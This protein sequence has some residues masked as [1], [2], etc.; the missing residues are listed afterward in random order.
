MTAVCSPGSALLDDLR[1]PRGSSGSSTI[2]SGGAI[3]RTSTTSPTPL[4]TTCTSMP[5]VSGVSPDGTETSSTP[6]V[7]PRSAS[8][9]ATVPAVVVMASGAPVPS[10]NVTRARHP[11][12]HGEA[13]ERD[14]RV[15]RA[16][17]SGSAGP[18]RRR[19][20]SASSTEAAVVQIRRSRRA[21]DEGQRPRPREDHVVAVGQVGG[22]SGL[23]PVL[24]RRRRCRPRRARRR[25]RRRRC[26]RRGPGRRRSRSP[27]CPSPRPSPLPATRHRRARRRPP[28]RTS[29]APAPSRDRRRGGRRPGRPRSTR[30]GGS[31]TAGTTGIGRVRQSSRFSRSHQEIVAGGRRGRRPGDRRPDRPARWLDRRTPRTRQVPL[32][33][34][35]AAETSTTWHPDLVGTGQK[36]GHGGRSRTTGERPDHRDRSA[37]ERFPP[38]LGDDR[39]VTASDRSDANCDTP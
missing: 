27:S 9:A 4:R 10:T 5:S 14:R 11:Q 20:R 29:G 13:G 30:C 2:F 1:R 26:A 22:R 8:S 17:T 32:Y 25:R 36:R 16:S 39:T 21:L 23:D 12:L 15:R 19:P 35:R 18:R 7:T 24:R 33:G 28:A 6:S 38:R 3:R 34:G 31:S 37:G